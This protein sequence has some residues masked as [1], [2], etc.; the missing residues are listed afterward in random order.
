[1]LGALGPAWA[2]ESAPEL[3]RL[4]V[5]HVHDGCYGRAAAAVH[6]LARLGPRYAD[7]AARAVREVLNRRHSEDSVQA[8][9]LAVYAGLGR[10]CREE[11]VQALHDM[12]AGQ[13]DRVITLDTAKRWL[14][15]LLRD[16]AL[17]ATLYCEVI[18]YEGYLRSR[19][20]H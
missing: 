9:A 6:H 7:E 10:A 16:P 20:E 2:D 11:A 15:R 3:R 14:E 19:I 12:I 17:A 8:W 5:K 1:M 13:R 18:D 4:I